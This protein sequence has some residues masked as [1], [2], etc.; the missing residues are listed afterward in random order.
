LWLLLFEA[1]LR[2]CALAPAELVLLALKLLLRPLLLPPPRPPPP[3]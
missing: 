1:L 2:F 3:L